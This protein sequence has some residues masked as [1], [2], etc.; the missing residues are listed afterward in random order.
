MTPSDHPPAP[1]SA[2]RTGVA[3]GAT[4][5]CAELAGSYLRLVEA[6]RASAARGYEPAEDRLRN[7]AQVVLCRMRALGCPVPD[8]A[9]LEP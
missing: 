9:E 1:A 8:P 3:V 4:P 2:P 5:R 6:I 7:R